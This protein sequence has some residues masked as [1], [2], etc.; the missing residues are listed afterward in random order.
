MEQDFASAEFNVVV[1]V[2]ILFLVAFNSNLLIIPEKK[3]FVTM[4]FNTP[5][6]CDVLMEKIELILKEE[7]YL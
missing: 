2:I 7:N 3:I 1:P 4:L 5:H 6:N